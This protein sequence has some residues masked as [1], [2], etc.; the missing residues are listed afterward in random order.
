MQESQ[1]RF[2]FLEALALGDLVALTPLDDLEDE[3]V[4]LPLGAEV[5]TVGLPLGAEVVT[6]GL[7][8]G[9]EVGARVGAV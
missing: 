3:A 8:L 7:P 5:I 1:T 9:A 4:G 2:P 6:V